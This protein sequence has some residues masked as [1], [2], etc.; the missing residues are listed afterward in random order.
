MDVG[1]PLHSW[2]MFAFAWPK[3]GHPIINVVSAMPPNVNFTVPP[4]P[5]AAKLAK[6]IVPNSLNI[7]CVA[8]PLQQNEAIQPLCRRT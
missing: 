7:T 5:Y 8:E 1:F 3:L 6:Q 2:K 4:N